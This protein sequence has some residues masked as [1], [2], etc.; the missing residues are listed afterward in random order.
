MPRAHSGYNEHVAL[1]ACRDVVLL[2]RAPRP[3]LAP[4][5]FLRTD[6]RRSNFGSRYN[7][8]CRN[9]VI[10]AQRAK[11]TQ[12][13]ILS[14]LPVISIQIG[15]QP[16][17]QIDVEPYG[18]ARL[19]V[20]RALR[21][22]S[23]RMSFSRGY[24]FAEVAQDSQWHAPRFMALERRNVEAQAISRYT[25]PGSNWRPSACEADV[26]ATRPQVPL[27]EQG[28]SQKMKNYKSARKLLCV[29]VSLLV[30]SLRIEHCHT[31]CRNQKGL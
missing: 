11:N 6:L 22:A 24:S 16:L 20:H 7:S 3:C 8:G 29:S 17:W 14:C 19:E 23:E 15:V 26:I 27:P 1:E 5:I 2:P 4:Q 25:C 12:C 18:R 31:Q 21:H 30:S 28:H 10:G 13:A 9:V